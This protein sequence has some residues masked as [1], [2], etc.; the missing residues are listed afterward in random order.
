MFQAE[1]RHCV[2]TT[3][4]CLQRLVKIKMKRA[5]GRVTFPVDVDGK[6]GRRSLY[7][8]PGREGNQTVKNGA[9]VKHFHLCLA[10]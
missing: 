10:L 6:S 7:C 1:S 2:Y 3:V 5:L 4:L 9:V 8:Q